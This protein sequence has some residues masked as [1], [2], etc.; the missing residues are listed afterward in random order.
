[1]ITTALFS[2]LTLGVQYTTATPNVI[3]R[4]EPAHFPLTR[5]SRGPKDFAGAANHLRAKYGFNTTH[6][7]EKRA[8]NTVAVP[9]TNQVCH[10]VAPRGLY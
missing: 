1:M 5:R 4:A 8:G 9:I 6:S 2:L 3:G 10:L 7:K